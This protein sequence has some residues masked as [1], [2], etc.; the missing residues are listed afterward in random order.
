MWCAS[1]GEGGLTGQ[2]MR[3]PEM[4]RYGLGERVA[5]AAGM[6]SNAWEMMGRRA[7]M[8]CRSG[9]SRCKAYLPWTLLG[10][11]FAKRAE[12]AVFCVLSDCKDLVLPGSD[13]LVSRAQSPWNQSPQGLRLLQKHGVLPRAIHTLGSKGG[14]GL[15]TYYRNTS[16]WRRGVPAAVLTS[17]LL[18]HLHGL[19]PLVQLLLQSHC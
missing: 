1:C 4:G 15:C 19:R 9:G 16:G 8:G 13:H 12:P 18:S 2:K 3:R 14:S 10:S 11:R 6:G 17:S 7:H 5:R